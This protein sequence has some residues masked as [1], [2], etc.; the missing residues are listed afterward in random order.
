MKKGTG[1]VGPPLLTPLS[2]DSLIDT[3]PPWT[4][5]LS[6]RIQPDVAIVIVRSNL[7]PGAT[8]FAKDK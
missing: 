5:R 6:S 2:E 1:E 4:T 8:A 7:W 3:V